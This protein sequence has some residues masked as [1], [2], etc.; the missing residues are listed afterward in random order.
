MAMVPIALSAS[1]AE[2]VAQ[3]CFLK[4]SAIERRG[5]SLAALLHTMATRLSL[6]AIRGN[7]RRRSRE[8]AFAAVSAKAVEPDWDDIQ[9]LIDEAIGW[10]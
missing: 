5:D 1:D 3:E 7:A 9:P 8:A 10:L 2:D 6:N 4:L